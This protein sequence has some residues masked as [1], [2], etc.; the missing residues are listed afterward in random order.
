MFKSRNIGEHIFRGIL[1]FGLL[2]VSLVYSGVL[3][4]WTMLPVVGALVSF[5]G[6]PTCWTVDLVETVLLRKTRIGCSDGS[7]G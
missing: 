4:W 5:R 7:C 3:G 2:A 6:C 1:G